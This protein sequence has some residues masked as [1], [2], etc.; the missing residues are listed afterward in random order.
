MGEVY[1]AEHIQLHRKVAVKILKASVAS[2]PQATERLQREAQS[3][4]GVGHPNIVDALDFGRDEHGRVYLV[5]EWLDGENLDQRLERG[6]MPI[7]TALAIV[8]QACTGLTEAHERGLVHRDVKPANLFLTQDRRGALVV[9]VLDFGIAKLGAEQN[10]LTA[11]GVLIG[12]PNYMAPE[13]ASG[14]PIDA[15]TD[16]YALGVILYEMLTGTVPFQAENAIAVLHQH[17]S[18]IPSAPSIA[19]PDRGIPVE[20]DSVVMRCLAKRP[21]DRFHSALDLSSALEAI[22]RGETPM[23][24]PARSRQIS[25]PR[26]EE[27]HLIPGGRRSPA[28]I[29]AIAAILAA[30]G[31]GAVWV[32]RRGSA[33]DGAA[34]ASGGTGQLDASSPIVGTTADAS[35]RPIDAAPADAPPTVLPVIEWTAHHRGHHTSVEG[36]ISKLPPRGESFQLQL[37]FIDSDSVIIHAIADGDLVAEIHLVHSTDHHTVLSEARQ[38]VTAEGRVTATLDSPRTGKHHIQIHL[39]HDGH[40]LED[41]ELDVHL[42]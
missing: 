24:A 9:K 10:K 2:D 28:K 14:E 7:S 31:L 36:E 41:L 32:A 4:S 29:I 15:R 12:T 1:E 13:Q 30:A 25:S 19:A 38:T 27:D 35:T 33:K 16:V 40:H 39:E 3:T 34:I 26:D 42:P 6:P 21:S 5:M 37:R 23:V 22:R 8:I 17:S 20:L 18:K 11:T